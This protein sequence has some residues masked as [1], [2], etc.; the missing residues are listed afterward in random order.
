MSADLAYKNTFLLVTGIDKILVSIVSLSLLV[1]LLSLLIRKLRQP[2]VIAY[3]LTGVLLGPHVAGLIKDDNT[4][5]NLG[6]LG[7]ILLLFFVGAEISVPDLTK[8]IRKP[9]WGALIQ[10]TLSLVSVAIIGWHMEWQLQ[11][12]VLLGFVISLSSSA[13][14][15]RYLQDNRE[16]NTPLGYLVSAILLIQDIII[17]PMLVILNFMGR[18]K[19]E[20]YQLILA[21]AGGAL[22]LFLL[23]FMIKKNNLRL[24]FLDFMQNDHE[25]QV[26][27]G[28]FICF[29]LSLITAFLG[30]SAALGAF[31]AGILVSHIQSTQ[32][33]Q[34]S[35]IPFRVFFL[36]LF[37]VS[38]G[39]LI[40]LNFLAQNY[41][42]ILGL[43]L[44]VF[45][46]NS[47]INSI[48]F[49][50]MGVNWRNSI[51]AGA[52][53]SQIGEFSFV[54]ALTGYRLNI[55]GDYSYQM[56][57]LII[58]LTMLMTSVWINIIKIFLFREPS[59]I[60]EWLGVQK[61]I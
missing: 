29:G 37:F 40:D 5:S 32:W 54:L 50:V 31:I 52:L 10:V 18:G 57:L 15:F 60:L 27:S 6:S 4:I 33:L 49:R 46:I 30:L 48:I 26:F 43:V 19:L 42:I 24:P 14:I 44:L 13:V 12:I 41:Q 28:L 2:Y 16:I 45:L 53:L 39:L 35:L 56:T 22:I 8:N 59:T 25:L 34:Q 11:I 3:I 9:L 61:R 1:L 55:I 51:Y 7:L 21:S 58:A 20:T 47:L 23:R 36:A 17:V 38:V